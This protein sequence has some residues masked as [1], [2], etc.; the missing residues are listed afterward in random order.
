MTK[1]QAESVKFR[2]VKPLDPVFSERLRIWRDATI[3]SVIEKTKET[4]R[5]DAFRL[6]W[7]EGMPNK[8]HIYWDSDVAKVLEGM[9]YALVHQPDP[10]LEKLYDEWV[11]LIVSAQQ[12]DGYLN[13][14]FTSV[15]PDK[16]WARL[17]FNHE[18]YCAGHLMEAAAAGWELLGKRK[19][20]H[21]N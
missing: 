1:N 3:P 2:E 21:C 20:N 17:S 13:T 8:P 9:A 7:K 5:I 15:E 11:D 18:L 16:R 10:E 14:Y 6:N 12:P 19:R 4:G